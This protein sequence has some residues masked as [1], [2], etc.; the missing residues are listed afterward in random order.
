VLGA[1]AALSGRVRPVEWR[2]A[3]RTQSAHEDVNGKA[4]PHSGGMEVVFEEERA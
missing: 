2:I 3:V 1:A 4:L